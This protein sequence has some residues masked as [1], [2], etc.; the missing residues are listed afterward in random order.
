VLDHRGAALGDRIP[1]FPAPV[2]AVDAPTDLITG[3]EIGQ[4]SWPHRV[5][6][7]LVSQRRTCY[8]GDDIADSESKLGV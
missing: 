7:E 4:G 8:P 3:I 6:G 1:Q 2:M 5:P